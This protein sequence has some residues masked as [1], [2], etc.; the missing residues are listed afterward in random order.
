LRNDIFLQF[1]TLNLASYLH[2]PNQ[3]DRLFRSNFK[4]FKTLGFQTNFLRN[5]L[6]FT[7]LMSGRPNPSDDQ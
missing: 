4:Y 7:F 1:N 6:I 3:K 2:S 5:F